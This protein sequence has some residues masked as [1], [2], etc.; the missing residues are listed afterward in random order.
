MVKLFD[1]KGLDLTSSSIVLSS[2]VDGGDVPRSALY[3][4]TRGAVSCSMITVLVSTPSIG[5]DVIL[6]LS[7]SIVSGGSATGIRGHCSDM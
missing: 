1:S 4:D 6:G 5:H 2:S 3:R 7:D